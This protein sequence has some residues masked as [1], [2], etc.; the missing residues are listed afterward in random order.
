MADKNEK[1]DLSLGTPKPK[2]PTVDKKITPKNP[3]L[4]QVIEESKANYKKYEKS[5]KDVK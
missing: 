5:V 1:K 4:K 3:S 2:G